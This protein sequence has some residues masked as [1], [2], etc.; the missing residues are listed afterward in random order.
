MMVEKSTYELRLA[1]LTRKENNYSRFS[2]ALNTVLTILLVSTLVTVVSTSSFATSIQSKLLKAADTESG[3]EY[4]RTRFLQAMKKAVNPSS[5][6]KALIIGD[7]HAQ[8][9]FNS[10]LENGY[11][12]DYRMSTRYIPVR[13]QITL[14]EDTSAF[15][16]K[17]DEV[18]CNE[19]DSLS[20]A[21]E[22]IAAADLI[23][24]AAH[25]KSWAAKQLPQTIQNLNIN[26]KQKLFVIGRKSY[27]KISVRNY[28]RLPEEK[29]KTLRTTVDNRQQKINS[30]MTKTLSDTM[31]INQH[32]LVCGSV[33]NCPVF[34]DTTEL[35]SY[36]GGHLTKAGARYVG[37]LLFDGSP[38][39]KL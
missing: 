25:W 4:V 18:F 32:E 1:M 27:G 19:S 28:L 16:A 6:K 34:T 11:L 8:D 9:F 38:L 13:C 2:I 20:K 12:K 36:D 10:V 33:N 39:G 24:F 15:I 21:K 23:I 26:S 7:S 29:L 30:I 17:K 14:I 35:I 3:G 31:F 37:K 5:K 22:E